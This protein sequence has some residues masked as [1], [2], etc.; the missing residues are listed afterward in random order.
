MLLVHTAGMMNVRVHFTDVV[1]VAELT[2]DKLKV[3]H[4]SKNGSTY[5]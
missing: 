4:D 1:E 5:R 2:A 3:G